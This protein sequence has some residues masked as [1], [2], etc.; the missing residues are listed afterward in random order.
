MAV[1]VVPIELFV[2]AYASD[3]GTSE[4]PVVLDN[5]ALCPTAV[6]DVPVLLAAVVDPL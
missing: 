6:L 5:I 2:S 1:L 4:D 3:G